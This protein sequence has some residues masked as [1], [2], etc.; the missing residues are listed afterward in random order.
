MR[1]LVVLAAGI[2]ALVLASLAPGKGAPPDR[3]C[4]PGFSRVHPDDK[5]IDDTS[6]A[7]ASDINND[8][9]ICLKTGLGGPGSDQ[10]YIDNAN[11]H[12]V[13]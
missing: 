11:P 3:G 12:F 6:V 9:W 8:S 7:Q 2:A 1:R 4:P 10:L 13:D 5:S